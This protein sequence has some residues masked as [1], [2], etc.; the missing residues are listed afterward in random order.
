V[1][2]R[3][4]RIA[5][6]P[7]HLLPR[8]RPRALPNPS[9]TE[10][11]QDWKEKHHRE[12]KQEGRRPYFGEASRGGGARAGAP[13]AGATGAAAQPRLALDLVEDPALYS[14]QSRQSA[15]KNYPTSTDPTPAPPLCR[16]RPATPPE[17]LGIGPGTL[18]RFGQL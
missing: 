1:L 10:A 11:G 2:C 13:T 9:A 12:L 15:R 17:G 16:L 14:K 3:S 8:P 4:T 18:R 6:S 5:L 7:C